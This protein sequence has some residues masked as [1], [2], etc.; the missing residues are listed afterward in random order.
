MTDPGRRRR[1][2][3]VDDTPDLLLPT[4]RRL[5]SLGYDV[6]TA[7]DGR[8]A[9][10]AIAARKP[11]AVVLDVM[12]PELNG[13]QVCRRIKQTDAW[14]DV[15]VIL[16]TAKVGQADRFWGEQAGADA[17]LTKPLDAALLEAELR[18]L[19]GA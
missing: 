7:T 15:V 10:D 14:K 5:T 6:E 18:R 11:D 4:R 1:V 2:L 19:I 8:Q 12:M 16:L 3:L 17:Y 13:F 9:L